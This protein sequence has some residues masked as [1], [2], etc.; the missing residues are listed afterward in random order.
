M[1]AKLTGQPAR[2]AEEKAKEVAE[3]MKAL[4]QELVHVRTGY[5]RST[6][7]AKAEGTTVT[8]GATADYASF[9]EFGTYK[10][11]PWPYLRPS[12][13]LYAPSILEKIRDGVMRLIGL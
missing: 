12:F 8:L 3:D 9:G 13:D 7:Y 1:L 11:A 10:M 2:I 5:L 6:I 4:S